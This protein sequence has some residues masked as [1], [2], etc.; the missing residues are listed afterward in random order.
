MDK[1]DLYRDIAERTHGDIYVGVVGPVRTGKSTFIKKFVEGVVLGNIADDSDRA[2]AVDELPQS[3]D[4]R[5]IMTSQPKFVPNEA[6]GVVFSDNIKANIRLI[7]CVGYYVDGAIG[8]KEGDKE[9]MVRTPWYNEEIPF[10]K[11]A[12][13]G[14]RKVIDEHSTIAVLVTTDGS[15][16]EIDRAQYI[17]AEERVVDELQRNGKPFAIILNTKTPDAPSTTKLA[18]ALSDKYSAPVIIKD[19]LNMQIEDADEIM[20]EILLEFPLKQVDVSAP[21]WLQALSPDNGIVKEL[22]DTLKRSCGEMLKMRDYNLLDGA[23]EG[24][25]YLDGFADVML[26]MGKGRMSARAVVKPD[27]FYKVLSEECGGDISDDYKLLSYVKQLRYA[28]VEYGKIKTALDDVKETGYGVVTPT[29]G[30]MLLEEPQMVKQGG[31]YGIKL[32]ASAPSLH[33]MRVDVETEV[34]PIVGTEQQ[35]QELVK[36]ML[37]EFEDDKGS[38]W[39]T[40]IFGKSLNTL[41]NDGLNNKLSAMPEE[42]RVKMRKT[43]G[44]IVNEGRGG[45]I[46]ILL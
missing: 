26:D 25:E 22:V 42:A 7:D 6:V 13:I 14:T 40:N 29:L 43:L 21:K 16:T 12:E 5:T 3:A 36:S 35:G 34:N 23:L 32:K 33:I 31:Q 41:V 10:E 8:N 30:E 27:V 18:D 28:E 24:A 9:R 4:G 38:I 37:A 15:I 19:V 2:R 44:R 46:C 45:V 39:N 1:F 17:A 20:E 11:A